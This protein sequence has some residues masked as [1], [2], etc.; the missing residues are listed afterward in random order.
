MKKEIPTIQQLVNNEIQLTGLSALLESEPPK[1]WLKEHELAK[2]PDGTPVLFLPIGKCEYLLRSIFDAYWFE[3][4]STAV[5]QNSVHVVKRLFYIDPEDQKTKRVDGVGG[6]LSREGIDI[7]LAKASANAEKNA[8]KKLGKIFGRDLSRDYDAKV[9]REIVTN[10]GEPEQEKI[11]V[12]KVKESIVAQL[13][14]TRK[15]EP[16][17][18][19]I[20]A[21]LKAVNESE[22][23]IDDEEI[24]LLI[25]AKCQKLG[26][27][28]VRPSF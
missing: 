26:V 7:A 14:K 2:N 19:C 21:F 8:C 12:N 1:E 24:N 20:G 23:N 18:R 9:E 10:L 3:I 6:A 22:V 17:R 25:Q 13:Q 27:D 15:A 28:Y 11:E 16:L 5:G 4:I